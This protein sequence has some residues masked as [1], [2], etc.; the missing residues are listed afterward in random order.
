MQGKTGRKGKRDTRYIFISIRD[1]EITIR[2]IS[3]KSAALERADLIFLGYIHFLA[4][5]SIVR[6]V[7]RKT[8]SLSIRVER[9]FM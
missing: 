2:D 9:K 3:M 5:E 7:G 4:I 8:S 6:S 1:Y